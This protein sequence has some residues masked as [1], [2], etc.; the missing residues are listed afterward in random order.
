MKPGREPGR[1]PAR[2]CVAIAASLWIAGCATSREVPPEAVTDPATSS[3]VLSPAAAE[4]GRSQITIGNAGKADVIAALGK[5]AAVVGFDSGYEVWVY[6]IRSAESV[7]DSELV[8]LF[9]PSGKLAKTRLRPA[10]SVA[11]SG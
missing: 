11:P 8:L 2:R 7:G 9:G 6:R 4:R 3:G 10:P 1:R 5:A